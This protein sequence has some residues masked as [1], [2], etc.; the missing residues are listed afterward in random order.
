MLFCNQVELRYIKLVSCPFS[1]LVFSLHSLP[2]PFF[3]VNITLGL[4]NSDR[5][6]HTK[7]V[8]LYKFNIH[9]QIGTNTSISTSKAIERAV[10]SFSFYLTILFPSSFCSLFRSRILSLLVGQKKTI[11]T[12]AQNSRR[13]FS[14]NV[15]NHKRIYHLA[16]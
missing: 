14:S 8:Y 16:V 15:S 2:F 6:K 5:H 12:M 1:C 9:A 7:D 10:S 4:A 3:L 11:I 13:S